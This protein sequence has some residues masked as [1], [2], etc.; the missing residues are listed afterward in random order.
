MIIRG[1]ALREVMINA[2]LIF[3]V[4]G[5]IEVRSSASAKANNEILKT[6]ILRNFPSTAIGY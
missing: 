1:I 3:S 4:T 5:D 2:H 6:D